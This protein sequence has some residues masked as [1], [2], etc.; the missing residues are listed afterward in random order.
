MYFLNE[1]GDY[2][3]QMYPGEVPDTWTAV[4]K[5]PDQYYDYDESSQDWVLNTTRE[6]QVLSEDVRNERDYLLR[7]MDKVVAN[8]LRW[9]AMS[10]EDQAA[11]TQYR[12]DLLN[13]P[14][15]QGFPHN[16][17]WPTKPEV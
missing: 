17:S 4:P 5:R 15:Q 9:A 14:Q 12:T 11:W 2:V 16:V 6:L 7:S 8:P 10:A 1:N 13:V 3:E